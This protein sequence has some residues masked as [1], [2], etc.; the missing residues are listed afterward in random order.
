MLTLDGDWFLAP[1]PDNTGRADGFPG[2]M[3]P[4]ARPAPV[5]GIIQQVFPGQHG[6]FWYYT[7]FPQ[8]AEPGRVL[9]HFGMVDYLA[10]VWL[11]G[12]RVGA[13][14]GSETPFTFDITEAMQPGEQLLAVRVLNPGDEPIDGIVLAE[15]PH[16]NKKVAFQPGNSFDSGGILMPVQVEVAPAVRI[17]DLCVRA[18]GATGAVTV[19]A[20]VQNDTEDTDGALVLCLASATAGET[21]APWAPSATHFA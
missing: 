10:E 7:R 9:L 21:K 13:H 14:E 20:T 11:N 15:T 1:D 2:A 3:P 18:D 4:T 12:I 16:R 6:V 19:I 5:P 17:T 8:P